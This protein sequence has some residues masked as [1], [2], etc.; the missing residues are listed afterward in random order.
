MGAEIDAVSKAIGSL[1]TETKTTSKVVTDLAEV[2]SQHIKTTDDYR[3]NQRLIIDAMERKV[4]RHEAISS[5]L[6][7]RYIDD[8]NDNH[9][10]VRAQRARAEFWK[11]FREKLAEK[12]LFWALAAVGLFLLS[13]LNDGARKQIVEW[14]SA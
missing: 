14:V 5:K 1:Q 3:T 9:E 6:D 4:E 10:F 8:L 2:I 13:L 11:K 7:V 12:S